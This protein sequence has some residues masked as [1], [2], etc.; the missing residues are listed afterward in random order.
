[1]AYIGQSLPRTEDHRFLTG[2]GRFVEDIDVPG[3]AWAQVVRSLH[4][5][6]G[7]TGIDTAAPPHLT[8]VPT[9]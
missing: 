9:A 2:A 5:H 6:A 8:G 3:V 4:A 7:I 1:M